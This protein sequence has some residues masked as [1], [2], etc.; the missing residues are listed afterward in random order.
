[1]GAHQHDAGEAVAEALAAVE[2][3]A[4]ALHVQDARLEPT[5]EAIVANAAAAHP[6]ARDAGL[7]LVIHGR[8]TPQAVTGR[9]PQILDLWQQETGEGP[10]IEAAATQEVTAISDTGTE[11]RWPKFCAAAQECGVGAMLC[12]PLQA[13]NRDIG[14]LSLYAPRPTTFTRGD[15]QLI[16]LFAA[17]AALALADAQRA[18][19]L[20]AAIAS[21]DL[22]GQA[23]G[24]LMER[25]KID[26]ETAFRTLARLSQDLNLKVTAVATRL[27]ETG[28]LPA[29]PLARPP[30][31]AREVTVARTPRNCGTVVR[32]SGSQ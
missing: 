24:I 23:K 9:G 3:L 5:L 1:V 22:I 10:C 27:A 21:R 18:E 8:L 7:I 2:I 13:G 17:L 19:Q 20:R 12:V 11:S 4:R 30:G 6:T 31:G 29:S 16:E 28:E 14:A 32:G 25:F 15:V 26:S